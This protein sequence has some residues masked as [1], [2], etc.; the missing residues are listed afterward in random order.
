M[1]NTK[2]KN[3]LYEVGVG[4]KDREI[5]GLFEVIIGLI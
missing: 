3:K 5:S 2:V 1:L 4:K